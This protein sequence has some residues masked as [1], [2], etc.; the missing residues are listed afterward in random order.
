MRVLLIEDDVIFAKRLQ[1]YLNK[2]RIVSDLSTNA[3]QGLKML[4]NFEYNLIITDMQLEGFYNGLQVVER[5]RNNLINDSKK[6]SIPIIIISAYGE[7]NDKLNSLNI[8]A[9][10]YLFKPFNCQELIA[11]MHSLIRR[12]SGHARNIIKYKDITIDTGSYV[13]KIN[14]NVVKLTSNEYKFLLFLIN[15]KGEAVN[16]NAILSHLYGPDE[17]AGAK[18]CDVLVCKIRSKFAQ[19]SNIQHIQTSWGIGYMVPADL[20]EDYSLYE[21]Y[22]EEESLS[23]SCLVS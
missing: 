8:G 6:A 19:F 14:D 23:Q 22:Q 4:K 21:N 10:E 17:M 7:M 11:K 16:K 1:D 5:I 3:E 12:S 2:N 18:I 9:D 15:K 13:V 20:T